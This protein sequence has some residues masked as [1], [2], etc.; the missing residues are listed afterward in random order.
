[1]LYSIK[2]LLTSLLTMIISFIFFQVNPDKYKE[3][4]LALFFISMFISSIIIFTATV[5]IIIW[6]F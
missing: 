1:M 5:Y 4:Y 2:V 3:S 6:T